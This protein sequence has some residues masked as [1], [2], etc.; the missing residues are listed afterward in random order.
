[1]LQVSD[2]ERFARRRRLR[3][4]ARDR[5]EEVPHLYLPKDGTDTTLADPLAF[6]ESANAPARA[7][8]P[9]FAFAGTKDPLLDD[10]RR[11]GHALERLSVPH[12]VRYYPR[13][14]HAFHAMVLDPMARACW[15]HQFAFLDRHLPDAPGP[16]GR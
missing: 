1:M 7:L 10:T 4:F 6:L 3:A 15:R 2:A 8:P 16:P 14:L 12:E 13:R 5:L 11:L 9:F